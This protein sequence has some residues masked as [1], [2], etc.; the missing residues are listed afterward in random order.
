MTNHETSRN[1]DFRK[2]EGGSKQ[3]R[4]LVTVYDDVEPAVKSLAADTGASVARSMEEALHHPEVDA[5]LVLRLTFP[6]VELLF[7][8]SLAG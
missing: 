3:G 8:S 4:R 6:D 5:V 7:G 2:T 1:G